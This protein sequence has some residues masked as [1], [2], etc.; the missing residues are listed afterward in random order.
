MLR[1]AIVALLGTGIQVASAEQSPWFGS[2]EIAAFQ[3][4]LPVQEAG[5]QV[6]APDGGPLIACLE[7]NCPDP[8]KLAIDAQDLAAAP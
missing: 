7:D 5:L 1:L 6:P 4:A 8:R 3:M 2:A